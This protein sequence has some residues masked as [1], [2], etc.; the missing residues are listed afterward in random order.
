MILSKVHKIY[1]N[2]KVF[3]ASDFHLG[4]PNF[5]KS[6]EREDRIIRWLNEIKPQTEALF[7]IGDIFDFWFEY[8]RVVPKGFIRLQ[9]KLAEFTDAGIQVYLFG[10][11]HD[12]WMFDYFYQELNIPVFHKPQIWLI[13]DQKF[14]IGHGDGLGPGDHV[15]KFFKKI[16][17]NQLSRFMFA[18]IHPNWG[19]GL[20]NYLSRRSRASQDEKESEFLGEKEWLWQ[21]CQEVEQQ[22]HHDYYVFGHRHLPLDLEVGA[23]SRYINTGDWLKYYTYACFDGESLELKTYKDEALSS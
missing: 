17:T 20:A 11:N 22:A 3:F 5:Q 7:L 12:M 18:T 15:Y 19:I 4:T 9:G 8:K 1:T 6:R 21:Y 23:Q 10:G 14:Y 13:N 2:K 16:F